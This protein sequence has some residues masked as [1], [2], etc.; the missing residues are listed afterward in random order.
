ML[1]YSIY[2]I[3][4]SYRRGGIGPNRRR[5]HM[6]GVNKVGV[7]MVVHDSTCEC[8]EGTML[9]SCLLKPCSYL[10]YSTPL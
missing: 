5:E 1:Q 10:P 2:H 9:E 4:A 8:F 3:I 6:A 7:N